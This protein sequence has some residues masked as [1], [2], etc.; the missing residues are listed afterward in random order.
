MAYLATDAEHKSSSARIWLQVVLRG[1]KGK[2]VVV[3]PDVLP[4]KPTI[5]MICLIQIQ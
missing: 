1:G 3:R 2:V 5:F 4:E